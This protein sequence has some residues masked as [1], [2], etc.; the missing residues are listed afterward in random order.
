[1][2]QAAQGGQNSDDAL[3]PLWITAF[4]FITSFSVWYFNHAII[5]RF[6]F[7][8]DIYQAQLVNLL[9]PGEPLANTIQY[10]QTLNPELVFWN[11]L[12]LITEQVGNYMRYIYG[13]VLIVL[14]F[15][16]D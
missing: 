9:W 15:F 12:I 1:M 16:I 10:I 3:A 8:L 14:A 5:V 13:A 6:I 4:I 11:D 7:K 2:P